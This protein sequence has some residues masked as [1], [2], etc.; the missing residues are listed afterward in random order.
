MFGACVTRGYLGDTEKTKQAYIE[1]DGHRAFRTQ[2]IGYVDEAGNLV[3][4]GTVII[5]FSLIFLMNH[6]LIKCSVLILKIGT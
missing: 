1:L 2:D 3:V 5:G 6:F 4:D